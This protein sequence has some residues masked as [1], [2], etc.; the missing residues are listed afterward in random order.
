[1]NYIEA[2]EIMELLQ[3][4][5]IAAEFHN[6]SETVIN[7]YDGDRD[8][9][10]MYLFDIT[11]PEEWQEIVKVARAIVAGLDAMQAELPPG[12]ALRPSVDGRMCFVLKDGKALR[13]ATKQGQGLGGPVWFHA[14]DRA[15]AVQWCVEHAQAVAK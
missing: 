6:D 10:G 12:Y 11:S 9:G 4:C 14:V 1:M 2:K 13:R 3:A 5:G 15:L 7:V 8:N